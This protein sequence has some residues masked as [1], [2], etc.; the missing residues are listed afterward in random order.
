MWVL[1]WA[2]TAAAGR[3]TYDSKAAP[4]PISAEL[5]PLGGNYYNIHLHWDV[6]GGKVLGAY[7]Y[8]LGVGEA[9]VTWPAQK[10]TRAELLA[11]EATLTRPETGGTGYYIEA[12]D[13]QFLTVSFY[14]RK[15]ETWSLIAVIP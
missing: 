4:A 2:G 9:H 14:N 10:F 5:V 7:L 15:A 11:G 13:F 6:T 1:L 3:P 8:G 12:G